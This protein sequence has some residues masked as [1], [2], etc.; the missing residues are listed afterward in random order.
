MNE[1]CRDIPCASV[2]EKMLVRLEGNPLR[3]AQGIY[4]RDQGVLNDR[5]KHIRSVLRTFIGRFG[6]RPCR[7]FRCPARINLRGMHV[8]TH[9]GYLNLMTHQREFVVVAAMQPDDVVTCVNTDLAFE[10]VEFSIREAM[11]H[12]AFAR[13]W[14]GFINHPDV[15]GAVLAQAGHWGNYLRGCAYN[16]QYRFPDALLRG[17]AI[18][19]GGDI[20]PGAAL[21][22]SSALCLVTLTALL[23]LN[24]K[25]PERESLVLAARDAEWYAGARVGVSDPA[26]MVLGGRNEIVNVALSAPELDTSSLRRLVWPENVSVLVIDSHTQ[27]SLSGAAAVEYNRNR[28]AYSLALGILR[29][30]MCAAGWP[31]ELV[32][33]ADRLSNLSPEN[34]RTLGGNGAL[35]GLL[36]R[37]PETIGIAE[38]RKRYPLPAFDDLFD[39]YFGAAPPHVRPSAIALRGPL[40]F[41]IA[42]SERA[43]VFF[44]ALRSGDVAAAGRLMTLGHEGD[45][46][47]NRDG[48]PFRCDLSDSALGRLIR[49]N[50]PIA[51]ISG[52]Y[53]ASSPVLDFIVDAALEAGALGA[54]LTGGGIAGTVLVLCKV[55]QTGRVA[56]HLACR[57]ASAEY[58]SLLKGR[59]PLTPAEAA[60]AVVMNCAPAC[61]GEFAF[62]VKPSG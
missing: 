27:R 22:S 29:Q 40:I 8:D 16:A 21:S 9:G 13:T 30:E 47:V 10:E 2:W 23:A 37:I 50:V 43:R 12:C 46:R 48:T 26:A 28:F 24:R 51:A 53:G 34:F 3:S 20:P 7:I 11:S 60:R 41:G 55:D 15:R 1:T 52:A 45:R 35:L 57:L 59:E 39:E 62:S 54:C 56:E 4:G 6:D 61:A 14:A 17:V 19:V 36:C 38:L 32:A 18:A 49:D 25:R 5:L 33:K 58:A 31:E 42:E 44:D